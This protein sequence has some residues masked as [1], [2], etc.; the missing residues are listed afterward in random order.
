MT[1]NLFSLTY[2]SR[3][4]LPLQAAEDEVLAIVGASREN[5][6]ARGITGAL[7]FSGSHF[8]QTLEGQEADVSGLMSVITKDPRHTDVMV[9]QEEAIVPG[10]RS[11]RDW[12]MA[13]NGRTTYVQRHINEVAAR[14]N[15]RQALRELEKLMRALT[16]A[17]LL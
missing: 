11:F 2:V 16:G 15:D 12:S 10:A 5:N 8:V 17:A 7:I 14:P 3:S 6:A 9:V 1:R 4:L 13:Y